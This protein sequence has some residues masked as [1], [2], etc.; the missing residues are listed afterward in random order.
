MLPFSYALSGLPSPQFLA[1]ISLQ[2]KCGNFA[3]WSSLTWGPAVWWWWC[4][5]T[6]QST[7]PWGPSQLGF[8]PGGS[9]AVWIP[10]FHLGPSVVWPQSPELILTVR[11]QNRFQIVSYLESS[12]GGLLQVHGLELRDQPLRSPRGAQLP[13]AA[14]GVLASALVGHHHKLN[15]I[16]H[17]DQMNC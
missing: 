2:M 15:L 17:L 11:N 16:A 3:P 6:G 8:S 12:P 13:H 9:R 10:E 1:Y 5:P 4:W 7:V 14:G